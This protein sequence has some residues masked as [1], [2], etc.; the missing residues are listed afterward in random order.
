[1]IVETFPTSIILR[2]PS[3]MPKIGGTV[4]ELTAAARMY[5]DAIIGMIYV[6]VGFCMDTCRLVDRTWIR[7]WQKTHAHCMKE[8]LC[9]LE[10]TKDPGVVTIHSES[11]YR[12]VSSNALV[13]AWR[14]PRL[15][16]QCTGYTHE[17][18]ERPAFKLRRHYSAVRGCKRVQD[19]T[20]Y[21]E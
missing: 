18:V 14:S 15:T 17:P 5:D 7:P 16:Y 8:W 11:L 21:Q 1:M 3:L 20:R 19:L 2:R 10:A 6:P 4:R 9:L 13:N 12:S